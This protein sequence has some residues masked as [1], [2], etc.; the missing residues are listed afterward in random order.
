MK[1]KSIHFIA[2]LTLLVAVSSC[3]ISAPV[4]EGKQTLPQTYLKNSDS[5]NIANISWKVFFQDTCLTQ[6]IDSALKNNQE[7]TIFLQE[8]AISQAEVQTRKGEYLPFLNLKAGAGADKVGRYTAQGAMEATTEME[9]GREMPEPVPDLMLGAFAHW[10]V[11]I[12]GKLH[13]AKNAAMKRYLA[14]V[15]GKNFLT[16]RL[17]TE[18]SHAYYELQALDKQLEILNQN[19]AI[20]SNALETVKMEKEATR[21]TE[22]A[23]SKFEAEVFKTK[24]LQ[25][26]IFQKITETENRINF[27]VGRFPQRVARLPMDVEKS[28]NTLVQTGVPMQL[29][30]NRPDIRQA[31]LELEASKLDVYVAKANFYPSLGLSGGVGLDAFHPVYLIRPQSM[32]F[33]LAGDLAAPLIN[34][35][36]IQ[37]HY[38][39]AN[40]KQIQ[41]LYEYEQTVLQAYTE[42]YNQLNSLQ[43]LDQK[44]ELKENQVN[45]LNRAVE[46]SNG[47]FASARADYMEVLMTQRDALEAKFELIETKM[48]QMQA[49]VSMYRALGGGWR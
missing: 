24:S 15:E 7:M 27:L 35:N 26:E 20:Q 33:S 31:E 42:V 28:A 49:N 36:A 38:K 46:V 45:A 8:L 13:R 21:V 23:V 10:E 40:A 16:T 32:L 47:L 34:R 44:R 12:W 6:L 4:Q 11:D 25:F 22:L 2:V 1:N 5:M 41:A 30:D 39:T 29:L 18:I 37:A 17:V 3:K 19:I 14:T 48:L 43:N 9:P